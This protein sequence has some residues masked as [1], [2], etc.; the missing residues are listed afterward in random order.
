M[1]IT[2]AD[3]EKLLTG[4]ASNSDPN[5]SIGGPLSSVQLVNNAKNNLF[6]KV[7]AQEAEDG[8]IDYRTDCF[9]HYSL[10]ERMIKTI[11]SIR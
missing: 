1:A 5:L 6:D 4:G 2:T 9:S 11:C 10:I 3:L 8:L 7:T